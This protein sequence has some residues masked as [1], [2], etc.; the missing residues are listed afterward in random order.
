MA[1][2]GFTMA[3]LTKELSDKLTEGRLQKIA[4]PEPDELLLGS[5]TLVF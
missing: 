5:L 3:A 4:Q 1:F 2:D